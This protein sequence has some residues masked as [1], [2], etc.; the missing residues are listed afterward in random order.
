[1]S[2]H[3]C[4]V[5]KRKKIVRIQTKKNEFTSSITQSVHTPFHTYIY[6]HNDNLSYKHTLGCAHFNFI[7]FYVNRKL[8]THTNTYTVIVN[9]C[10][11]KKKKEQKL[12]TKRS[13]ILYIW[14]NK[15]KV[16]LNF[17]L[18][19]LFLFFVHH[20]P[21]TSAFCVDE[22]NQ[23]SSPNRPNLCFDRRKSL[24][25]PHATDTNRG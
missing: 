6:N 23:A 21:M 4:Y 16:Q 13:D 1:M 2:R 20:L 5:R 9:S 3:M 24:G 19:I 25:K 22:M 10:P 15:K 14:G 7:S 17:Y 12:E 11:Q 18:L 8:H